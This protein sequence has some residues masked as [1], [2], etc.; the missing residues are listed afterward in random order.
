VR[1]WNPRRTVLVAM[2]SFTPVFK[3]ERR[4]IEVGIL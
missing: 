3:G 1:P 4:H 2:H